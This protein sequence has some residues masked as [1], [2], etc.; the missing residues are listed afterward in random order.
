MW[1][2]GIQRLRTSRL[3]KPTA[4]KAPLVFHSMPFL[5]RHRIHI[6]LKRLHRQAPPTFRIWS[7]FAC[8]IS[9]ETIEQQ[10]KAVTQTKA[11]KYSF[12]A[13]IYHSTLMRRAKHCFF[14][15]DSFTQSFVWYLNDMP[16]VTHTVVHSAHIIRLDKWID[17]C[18]SFNM[19]QCNINKSRSNTFCQIQIS[20]SRT[21]NTLSIVLYTC[22][23]LLSILFWAKHFCCCCC[24][25]FSFKTSG[26]LCSRRAGAPILLLAIFFLACKVVELHFS[27]RL[28][29][30]N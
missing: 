13:V 22:I 1:L 30:L 28:T 10:I 14:L 23:I 19:Q 5:R 6:V 21:T 15:S 2:S 18:F 17:G 8:E 20:V 9:R 16:G 25:C 4:A 29:H 11:C 7:A 12:Y 27:T 26:R 3:C 24:F